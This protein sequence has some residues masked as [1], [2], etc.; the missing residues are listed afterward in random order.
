MIIYCDG[1]CSGNQF[2]KNIGGWGAILRYKDSVKEIYGGEINTSNQR[3]ELTA[4][5]KALEQLKPGDHEITVYTDSAYLFNCIHKKWYLNWQK[6]GWRNAR[7]QPVE[8]RDLWE[9]LLNL[10]ASQKVDFRK[11]AGHSGDELNERADTLAKKG[12]EEAKKGA[13]S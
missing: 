3:M 7:K 10:T 13:R 9:R 11:V 1:A 6:N 2:Q 5:I 8:N 4:C 12:I